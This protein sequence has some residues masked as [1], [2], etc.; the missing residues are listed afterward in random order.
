L[1]EALVL[2][3]HD[4]TRIVILVDNLDKAW[5]RGE[6][7]RFLCYFFLG[8]L[9]ALR[10][11]SGDFRNR[12]KQQESLNISLCVFVRADIFDAVLEHAREPDKIQF[13]RIVW[14]DKERLKLIA[15]NR[16]VAAVNGFESFVPVSTLWDRF[17]VRRV[18]DQDMF[19]FI[20]E[21]ILKRPRDLIFFLRSAISSATNRRHGKVQEDDFIR[22]QEDYSNFV[23]QSI[24]VELRERLPIIEDIIQEFIGRDQ[25]MTELELRKLLLATKNA[26]NLDIDDVIR[27]LCI[28]S[29]LEIEHPLGIYSSVVDEKSYA[30]LY[31]A[32][33]NAAERDAR[34]V[35]FRIH[36]AF[37]RAL[38]INGH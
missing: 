37:C 16:I 8:L 4:K 33:Y 30:K 38:L 23:L 34:P 26:E 28:N 24:L 2:A 25:V 15:D 36:R 35:H 7:A 22:A 19:D 31:R 5:D 9:S 6:N 29:F 21:H 27:Y 32:A 13:E 17:F 14:D 18:L 3:L 10:R 11:I 1:L 20:F 12:P